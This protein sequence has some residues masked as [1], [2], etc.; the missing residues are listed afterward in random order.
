MKT[1]HWLALCAGL[2]LGLSASAQTPEV[3]LT[4]IDCGTG[5]K[6]TNVNERFSD[7]FAYKDLN[8]VFTFSCYLIKHGDLRGFDPQEIEVIGLIARY[9]RRASPK[10][11][12]PGY[13]ELPSDLRKAVKVLS[14]IV[15]LAEGLDRSHVQVLDSITLANRGD[16]Y[17]MQ[18]RTNGDAELEL[19]AAGRHVEP[20]ED[21]LGKPVRFEV[22]PAPARA[23]RTPVR[24]SA[25]A[26]TASAG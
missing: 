11:G 1:Q 22:A 19:W 26:R 18:L 7:T 14:S 16:D 4:R 5:A 24:A 17:L 9:H 21:T 3:T 15:R 2:L 23:K 12:H 25:P 6:P 20:L 13:G 10:K 8:L